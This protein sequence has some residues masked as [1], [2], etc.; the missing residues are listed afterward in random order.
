MRLQSSRRGGVRTAADVGRDVNAE[1]EP[2]RR[3][4]VRQ[5]THA[6][7][8]GAG[9][10]PWAAATLRDFG[11]DSSGGTSACPFSVIKQLANY[12]AP[13]QLILVLPCT[14]PRF[15]QT[16][17]TL[18]NH[19]QPVLSDLEAKKKCGTVPGLAHRAVT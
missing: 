12:V 6:G 9:R 5:A 18:L 1:R 10:F 19:D 8:D 15:Q 13:T 7:V 3:R 11:A 16:A 14:R 17:L 4:Q 2:T